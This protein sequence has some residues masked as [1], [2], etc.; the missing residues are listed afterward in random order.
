VGLSALFWIGVSTTAGATTIALDF[1]LPSVSPGG[2]QSV[3]ADQ[4]NPDPATGVQIM[5]FVPSGSPVGTTLPAVHQDDAF[6]VNNQVLRPDPQG[7][8]TSGW[9]GLFFSAAPLLSIDLTALDVGGD[10]LILEAFGAIDGTNPLGSFT[11]DGTGR[12]FGNGAIDPVSLSGIGAI[13]SIVLRQQD[14]TTTLEDG[15]VVDDVVLTFVPEPTTASL[16]ALGIGALC[17]A[18]RRY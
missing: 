17:L 16:L 1:E 10:G 9:I 4:Y 15:W 5:F 12:T 6:G 2:V 7:G 11:I 14:D 18:R 3:T 13:R 8:A